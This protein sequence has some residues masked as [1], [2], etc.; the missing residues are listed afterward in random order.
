MSTNSD[1]NALLLIAAL[2]GYVTFVVSVARTAIAKLPLI[3]AVPF[4]VAI[5]PPA[6]FFLVLS[7]EEKPHFWKIYLAAWF[8][9]FPLAVWIFS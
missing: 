5:S 1:G 6:V 8:I 4:L 9:L 2:G 7:A 3:V